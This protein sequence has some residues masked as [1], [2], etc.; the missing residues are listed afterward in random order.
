MSASEV[1]SGE[2]TTQGLTQQSE[3][4]FGASVDNSS[5]A[6]T[7]SIEVTPKKHALKTNTPNLSPG[8]KRYRVP[9]QCPDCSAKFANSVTWM[10]HT[11]SNCKDKSAAKAADNPIVYDYT[12]L[13][14]HRDSF[15][16]IVG[17]VLGVHTVLCTSDRRYLLRLTLA[18]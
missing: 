1:E 16:Q 18:S 8:V 17:F 5:Q 12:T 9:R 3:D 6:S 7:A 14:K 10:I 13:H 4:L 15:I 2:E 11:F